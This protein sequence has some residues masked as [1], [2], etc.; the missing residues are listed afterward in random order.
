MG[1]IAS[2]AEAS[3][4]QR[5]VDVH[6]QSYM[7]REFVGAA[8]LRGTYVEGNEANDDRRPQGFLVSQP[9]GSVTPPHFHETDQFQ[10][11]V[12]GEG[13]FGKQAVAPVTVQ[14][15]A[16]HTPYGPIRAGAKGVQYYTLRQRWDPGAKYMPAM[17]DR[18][19]RGRQ[20][21]RLAAAITAGQ[22]GG[23]AG[24][25]LTTLM[26]L[27]PD[28]LLACVYRLQAGESLNGPDP[29]SGG[30]QYQVVLHGALLHGGRE[31]A[32]LS[33]GYLAPEDERVPLLAG[34]CGLVLLVMQFPREAAASA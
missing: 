33:V 6:G 19:V 4:R 22:A 18:L 28:G 23:Q 3:A 9:P 26:P 5:T 15:A 27:E 24:P 1:S 25:A 14:F 7:L 16:G 12:A 11:F 30:G 2:L 34:T 31:Y 21:Q 13:H 29:A 32:R 17:R 8:P 20:R 10:V